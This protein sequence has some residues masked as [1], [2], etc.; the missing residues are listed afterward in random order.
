MLDYSVGSISEAKSVEA[1]LK[2][3][4]SLV[5]ALENDISAISANSNTHNY[6]VEEKQLMQTYLRLN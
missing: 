6:R 5:T 1:T 4:V 2:N 3:F